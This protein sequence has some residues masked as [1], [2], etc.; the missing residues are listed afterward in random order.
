MQM[1]TRKVWSICTAITAAG[2]ALSCMLCLLTYCMFAR[3]ATRDQHIWRVS[4][5]T[6]GLFHTALR[7]KTPIILAAPCG[8]TLYAANTL[9]LLSHELN[10][11]I[12]SCFSCACHTGFPRLPFVVLSGAC[13]NSLSVQ[14]QCQA[15]F[16]SIQWVEA[17]LM[18]MT[19]WVLCTIHK[20]VTHD[21]YRHGLSFP[22]TFDKAFQTLTA[23]ACGVQQATEQD[24]RGL[25]LLSHTKLVLGLLPAT[26][27]IQLEHTLV[28]NKYS[29]PSIEEVHVKCAG[30]VSFSR[31]RPSGSS[32]EQI[33]R[34]IC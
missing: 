26:V 25:Q 20:T 24:C 11:W 21:A 10:T 4:Y 22:Y 19:A 12:M 2:P 8:P 13:I 17:S 5:T 30:K 16:R 34:Q 6:P 14:Y 29:A 15:C 28:A 27:A 32:F 23:T 18:P 31:W 3:T 33:Q 7:R 1:S 9:V